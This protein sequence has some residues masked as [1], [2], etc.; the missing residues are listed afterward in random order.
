MIR[1]NKN[2]K[3]N[4]YAIAAL[5]EPGI[6]SLKRKL[7]RHG[8]KADQIDVG[9]SAY[10]AHITIVRGIP[11]HKLAQLISGLPQNKIEVTLSNQF[12]L[13]SSSGF[14]AWSIPVVHHELGD[15]YFNLNRV[16][17]KNLQSEF[18]PHVTIDSVTKKDTLSQ[19]VYLKSDLIPHPINTNTYGWLLYT[20]SGEEITIST[21]D[22]D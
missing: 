18:K 15:V 1:R 20:P 2:V 17:S 5:L 7:Q 12:E 9:I 21:H 14:L 11:E 19:G 10:L 6:T 13:L 22:P 8:V 4:G 16:L 3:Y